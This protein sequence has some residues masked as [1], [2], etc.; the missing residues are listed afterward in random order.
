MFS[1]LVDTI[2][3]NTIYLGFGMGLSFNIVI[4]IIIANYFVKLIF[5][6]IDTPL[7]YLI[8]NIIKKKYSLN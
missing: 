5:A 8:V 6:L 4:K 7:V 3:L 2:I 1:Q